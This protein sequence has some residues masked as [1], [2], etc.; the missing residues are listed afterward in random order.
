MFEKRRRG[1]P[2]PLV[3][4]LLL[5]AAGVVAWHFYTRNPPP[6]A[7]EPVV[8][9]EAREYVHN[10]GLKLSD[11]QMSAKESFAGSVLV[12][13]TGKITNAGNKPIRRVEVRCVFYDPV[14]Q[15]I[16]RER[17]PIVGGRTGGLKPGETKD[18][19][20]PFDTIPETWNQGLPQLVIAQ[21]VFGE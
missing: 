19:R 17:V 15:A 16:M 11:V 13:V 14:G 2:V 21:I 18:F 1:V 10:G 12:E 8:T 5:A 6:P 4:I 3:A 20:L 9:P 7:P